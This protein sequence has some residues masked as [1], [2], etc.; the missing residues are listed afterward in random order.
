M[1]PDIEDLRMASQRITDKLVELCKVPSNEDKA[2]ARGQLLS[3]PK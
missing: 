2:A 1:V 3:F